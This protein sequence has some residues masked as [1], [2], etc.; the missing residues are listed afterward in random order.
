M[1]LYLGP[2]WT[3]SHQI[4]TVEVFHHVLPTYGIRNAEMQKKV[5]VTSSLRYSVAFTKRK[6]SL[7]SMCIYWNLV[8]RESFVMTSYAIC[9][10]LSLPLLLHSFLL[11]W[12]S[13][14]TIIDARFFPRKSYWAQ[15]DR[16]LPWLFY[17]LLSR[18]PLTNSGARLDW[19]GLLQNL[20]IE[21]RLFSLLT[22][23]SR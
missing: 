12:Q 16:A 17:C 5:L 2:S 22:I 20:R 7:I 6:S 1:R 8:I 11:H 13:E 9:K 19:V 15:S 21:Y 10:L 23:I 14:S 18:G 4:W 3:D